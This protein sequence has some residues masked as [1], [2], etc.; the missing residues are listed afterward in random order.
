[1]PERGN[2]AQEYYDPWSNT[3][4]KHG[5]D[6]DLVISAL[7]KCIRRGDEATAMRMAYELY[8]T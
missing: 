6:A 7:Q 4:T 3:K 8:V 5:L 1:M 2:M